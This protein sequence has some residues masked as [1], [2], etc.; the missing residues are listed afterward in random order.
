MVIEGRV[1]GVWFRGWTVEQAS[2]CALSGWVR[3]RSDGSV[4]ALFHGSAAMV[5]AMIAAC[6]IGPPAA[7]V[8]HL[9]VESAEVPAGPGFHSRPTV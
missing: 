4:E 2:A 3:N 8:S 9:S 6:R 5:D 1:Q 7:R